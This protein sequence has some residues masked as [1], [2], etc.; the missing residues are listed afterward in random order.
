MDS[1]HQF[2]DWG[3]TGAGYTKQARKVRL[4]R[5]P[6][7]GNEWPFGSVSSFEKLPDGR[8]RLSSVSQS[9]LDFPKGQKWK[10]V[11]DLR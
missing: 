9:R 11:P 5:H 10:T 6:T 8:A 4:S 7:M 1:C 2:G 3:D